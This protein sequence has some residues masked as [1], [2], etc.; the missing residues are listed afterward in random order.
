MNATLLVQS[1]YSLLMKKQFY[2]QIWS[3]RWGTGWWW[4]GWWPTVNF[5]YWIWFDC[6]MLTSGLGVQSITCLIVVGGKF[7]LSLFIYFSFQHY[8]IIHPRVTFSPFF[9]LSE[10]TSCPCRILFLSPREMTLLPRIFLLE[11]RCWLSIQK[12]LHFIRQLLSIA[13][14]R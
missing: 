4:W 2:V 14:A 1:L 12:Q 9:L 10:H 8:W 7:I 11:D 6:W 3:T 5:F 13:T